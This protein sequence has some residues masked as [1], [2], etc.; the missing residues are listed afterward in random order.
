MYWVLGIRQIS[1]R[2]FRIGGEAVQQLVE[3]ISTTTPSIQNSAIL[4]TIASN[5]IP[6]LTRQLDELFESTSEYDDV[7]LHH[8]IASLCK[9]S[10]DQ[11][12]VHK[13]ETYYSIR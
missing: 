2:S 9:L 1:T 10:S 8:V 11:M 5:E 7:A 6:E 12:E 13:Y 3:Q 4:T